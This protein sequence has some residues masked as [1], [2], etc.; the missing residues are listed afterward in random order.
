MNDFLRAL[1][2]PDV[3]FARYAL[4]AGLIA[5]VPLGIV[6]TL[7]VVRRVSYLAAA[8]SHAILGGIGL[9]L[10]L[11][12]VPGCGWFHPMLGAVLAALVAAAAVGWVNLH[13]GE[14]EDTAIGAIWVVGMAAGLVFIQKTPGYVDA[15]SYLFGNVLLLGPADLW[16]GT[17]L[18]ALVLAAVTLFYRRI[19]AMVFDPEFA[20]LRGV[21]VERLHYLMLALTALTVTFLVRLVGIVLVIALLTLPAAIAARFARHLWQMMIGAGTLCALLIAAGLI[22]SHHHAV[23]L[24]PGPVIILLGGLVYLLALLVPTTARA[25]PPARPRP[26]AGK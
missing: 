4:A 3:P 23:D 21:N 22:V 12:A 14:R 15:M 13:G 2:N 25:R 6:G 18:A 16:L 19:H 26:F 1:A 5:S 20:R 11:G 8:I 24:N 10:F 7:V 9:G 17:G